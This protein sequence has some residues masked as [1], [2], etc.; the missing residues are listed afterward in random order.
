MAAQSAYWNP[1]TETLGRD[2]LAALQL[3]EAA[4]PGRL[5][6]RPQP[7]VPA[8][9]G[10][11]GPRPAPGAGRPAA[12]ADVDARRVDG[13]AIGPPAVRR[14]ADDRRGGGDPRPHHLGDVRQTAAAGIG[15]AQGLGVDRGDVGVRDLGLRRAAGRRRLHRVRLRLV[16]RVLGTALLDGEDR[17]PQ[18]PRRCAD[19]RGPRPPDH[20]VRCDRRRLDPHLRAAPRAGGA[21]A[22]HRSPQLRRAAGDPLRRAGRIDPADQGD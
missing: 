14:T 15:L 16:R 21:V 7:L 17:R 12:A 19:D 20:R 3:V 6:D 4:S 1:K 2:R 8:R 5:G 11:L 9:A 22:R 18:R 13:L 10:R